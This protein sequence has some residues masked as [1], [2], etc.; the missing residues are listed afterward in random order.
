[1]KRDIKKKMID[2]FTKEYNSNDA[3]L[4][5]SRYSAGYGINYLLQND[6][7]KKYLEIINSNQFY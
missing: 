4:K 1:M 7:A 6:Y 3:I 5:Y 2:S